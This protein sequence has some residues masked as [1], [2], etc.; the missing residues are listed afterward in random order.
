M[1]KCVAVFVMIIMALFG[2]TACTDGNNNAG[3]GDSNSTGGNSGNASTVT[4]GGS[5]DSTVATGNILIAYFSCT[6]N[7]EGIA[8]HIQAETGGTLYEIVPQVPYTADDLKYYTGC[9]ADE[10]NADDNA[11]PA[12]NESVEDMSKYDTVFLG[13]PIWYGK[14][15]KIVYTFLESYDFSGKKIIPFCTSASSPIGSSDTNLHS[16]ATNAQWVAG[17]RFS[18]GASKA[19]VAEW[20]KGLN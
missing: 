10:E 2:L 13:Y 3:G 5:Q 9:R 1:K 11:R 6:S 17:R 15:P 4:G 14:A 8:K 16:L 7:T 18:A 12:I 19:T 20:I